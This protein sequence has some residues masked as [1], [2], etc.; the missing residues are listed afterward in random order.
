M[1]KEP[2]KP[3]ISSAA[4]TLGDRVREHRT[5]LGLTQERLAERSELHW[6]YIGQ[7]ERGQ[8]NV[9]LHNILRIAAVLEVD[10]GDLIRG[11]RAPA[12]NL[13]VTSPS[14]RKTAISGK[15]TRRA[16][17]KRAASKKA[18]GMTAAKV[19]PKRPSSS[20]GLKRSGTR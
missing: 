5:R 1:P 8:N 17:S 9:T 2:L 15:T 6:S 13:Q 7:V 18:R 10:A 19:A 16:P 14:S 4:G 11:L 20:S 3:P 12:G